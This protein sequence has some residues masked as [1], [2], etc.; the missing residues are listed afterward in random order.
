M[1]KLKRAFTLIELLIVI[2]IIGI[3]VSIAIASFA[4]AQAR[5]RDA[6]RK[7]D[8]DAIKKALELAKGDTTGGFYPGCPSNATSCVLDKTPPATN[9]ELAPTYIAS[10]PEDPKNTGVHVYTFIPTPA[11]CIG[12]S[13]VGTPCNKYSLVA[14]LENSNDA[15]KDTTPDTTHCPAASNTVSYTVNN[16]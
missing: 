6:R 1:P 11:N 10:T 7:G 14:C 16:P 8:L 4:S 5:S 13:G 2:T 9:P 15:Q 3:L 12:Q